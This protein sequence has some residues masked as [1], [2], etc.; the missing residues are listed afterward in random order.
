M[1]IRSTNR[2]LLAALFFTGFAT[3]AQAIIS[4]LLLIEIGETFGYPVGVAGQ[5]T[6]AAS[7]VGI[8]FALIMGVLALRY[9]PRTLLLTGMGFFAASAIACYIAPNFPAMLVAYALSGV[10]TSMT[11]PMLGTIIGETLPPEERPRAL[12]LITAGQPISFIVGTPIVNY[13]AG[14]SGWRMAF[15]A[16]MLPIVLVSFVVIYIGVP[17]IGDTRRDESKGT[18]E[19][20]RGVLSRRSALACLA[21]T[22]LFQASMMTT[23]NFSISFFRES[24]QISTGWASL[25]LSALTLFAATGN[26]TTGAVIQRLGRRR[27]ATIFALMLGALAIAT[28]NSGILTLSIMTLMPWAYL[29]GAGYVA[30]DSLTLEQVPEYRGTLMSL[31]TVARSTGATVGALLLI[32]GYGAFGLVMGALGLAAALIYRVSTREPQ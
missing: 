16:Y 23:F 24:Y 10:A 17:R 12:G 2:L 11:F 3:A 20:F 5:V 30:G 8:V 6:T 18:F 28:Y 14:Q 27:T 22:A 13:I 1:D 7:S 19:G 26:L 4:S 32:Y 21:A 9:R 31:N 29:A 25:L 15:L